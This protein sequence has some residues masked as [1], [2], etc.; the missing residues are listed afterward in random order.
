M[1]HGRITGWATHLPERRL[2]NHDLAEMV[3]TSDEWIRERSGIGT[4]HV[5]GKVTEMSVEAGRGAMA[6]PPPIGAAMPMP[7]PGFI[8]SVGLGFFPE[9][10][11]NN[12]IS[13]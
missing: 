9:F 4:R 10:Q 11:Q 8:M 12:W 13:Q 2:T 7:S 5:D 1:A 3:D 6:M